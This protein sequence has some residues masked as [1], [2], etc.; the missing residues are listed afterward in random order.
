[1]MMTYKIVGLDKIKAEYVKNN[2]LAVGSKFIC[3]RKVIY[4]PETVGSP[5][6]TIL[7]LFE[8]FSICLELWFID[9]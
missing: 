3:Q 8:G 2:S 1:M 4:V 5:N 9:S 7:W 6:R